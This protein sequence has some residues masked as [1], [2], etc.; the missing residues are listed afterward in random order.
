[1]LMLIILWWLSALFVI[2]ISS[3]S[4]SRLLSTLWETIFPLINS[5]PIDF[6]TKFG[7]WAVVTGSTDGIGKAYA[8]ELAMRHI[9]L[10][11]ISRSLEKLKETKSELLNINPNIEVKIIEADFSKGKPIFEKIR[12]QLNE[13]IGIL[14]NNVGKM[15]KYPMYLDE[16]PEDEL[17]ELMTIN[18]GATT[19]MTRLIIEQMKQRRKGA[20]INISSG[21]E[22]Q[23]LPLMT[24]YAA[25][26]AYLKSFS[27]A[28]RMEYSHFG[29]T[30]QHLAPLFINTKMN[31]FSPSLQVS[32]IFIPNAMTYAKNAI[33]TLGKV[34]SS[35]GYWAHGIQTFITLTAPMSLRLKIGHLL[36]KKFRNDYFKYI[37]DK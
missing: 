15:Y 4:I 8:K 12:T 30:I 16:V 37:K 5:T 20:I 22:H 2:W 13:P 26:K 23:P 19:M 33:A 17:W 35:S 31:S 36:V 29:I 25:T 9:N 10:I 24:V 27:D 32:S 18:V 1:M 6:R 7:E 21:S 28:I 14:V 34:D 3:I 11:L